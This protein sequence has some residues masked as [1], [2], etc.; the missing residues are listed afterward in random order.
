MV[1]PSCAAR[2][3]PR[4]RSFFRLHLLDLFDPKLPATTG[5]WFQLRVIQALLFT[6]LFVKEFAHAAALIGALDDFT[7]Q[8]RDGKDGEPAVE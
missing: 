6:G 2:A 8:G 5:Q 3:T 7:Q 1:W 4:V